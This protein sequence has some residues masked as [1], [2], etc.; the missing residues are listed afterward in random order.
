MLNRLVAN[1]VYG[2]FLAGILLLLL[3]P[4]ILRGWSPALAVTFLCLPAYMVHQYEEHD[5]DRFRRLVN[6]TLGR[7]ANV[8]PLG[9]VFLINVPG[10]WG[11]IAVSLGL[12]VMV[13]IG[14]ASIAA[15]LLLVN[16]VIHI[17]HAMIFRSYN[18][19]LGTA[20]L[21]FLPLGGM[22]IWE[23]QRAGGTVGSQAVGLIVAIGIHVVI[24]AYVLHNRR[25]AGTGTR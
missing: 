7:G 20:I 21:L 19:G 16:A 2:G 6:Q 13:N 25:M 14:F 8:L 1:W 17:A 11:V 10:V 3:A 4:L 15:Y 23:I 5:N 18:P 12:A 22:D 9:A 24:I